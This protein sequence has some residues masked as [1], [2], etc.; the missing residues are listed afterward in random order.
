MLRI[1]GGIYDHNQWGNYSRQAKASTFCNPIFCTWPG[2]AQCSQC[3]Y[4][5]N[6]MER[7]QTVKVIKEY[8]RDLK[9]T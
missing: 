7:E 2:A 3:H 9:R 1:S 6:S 4:D 5:G 8:C